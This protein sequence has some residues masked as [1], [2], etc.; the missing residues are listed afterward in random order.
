MK[1]TIMRLFVK[2]LEIYHSN[3]E[4]MLIEFTFEGTGMCKIKKLKL[5]K[6]KPPKKLM[7]DKIL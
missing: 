2:L 5:D 4:N 6:L 1:L 3:R 7:I